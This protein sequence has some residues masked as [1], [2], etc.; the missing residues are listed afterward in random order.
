MTLSSRILPSQTSTIVEL[1]FKDR[2]PS[3]RLYHNAL[4]T[5][6]KE[7]CCLLVFYGPSGEGKTYLLREIYRVTTTNT[8]GPRVRIGTV[9]LKGRLVRESIYATMW[10]RA[11]LGKSNVRFPVYDFAFTLFWKSAYPDQP[12]PEMT[13]GTFRNFLKNGKEV[14][15]EDLPGR[16]VDVGV[17]LGLNFLK[18][19]P[20][21]GS[22]L[23]YFV[24]LGVDK[25]SELILKQSH[26]V[27]RLLFD[28]NGD[29]VS[30]FKLRNLLPRFLAYD[31][32]NYLRSHPEEKIVLLVDEYE[33]AL[34]L[35]GSGSRL[36]ESP[37]DEGIRE[38][39][40]HC[41]NIGILFV[42]FS[43][44][45]LPW[46]DY[47][48]GWDAV[49]KDAH[50]RV[51]SLPASDADKALLSAGVKEPEIRK[52]I[53]SAAL[54]DPSMSD[55][56]PV[57]PVML[58]LQL[59]HYIA[60]TQEQ[61]RT[62]VPSDFTV[63]SKSFVVR[64]NTLV[65]RFFRNYDDSLNR[66]LCRIAVAKWFDRPL[67]EFI[68]KNFNT[69]FP[70]DRFNDLARLSFIQR[71]EE[72]P[73]RFA[74]HNVIR[75]ALQSFLPADDSAATHTELANYLL[76]R[77]RAANKSIL[78]PE[79]V[80]IIASAMRHRAEVDRPTMWAEYTAFLAEMIG[81]F[82]AAESREQLARDASDNLRPKDIDDEGHS[83]IDAITSM[84]IGR[85]LL[86][87]GKQ[88]AAHEVLRKACEND[89]D[90]EIAWYLNQLYGDN[91]INLGQA[92]E[93]IRAAR[94]AVRVAKREFGRRHQHVLAGYLLSARALTAS[95]RPDKA[96][97]R[98]RLV[99]AAAERLPNDPERHAFRLHARMEAADC[100]MAMDRR[101][102]AAN[103]MKVALE[104]L[105]NWQGPADSQAVGAFFEAA[106]KCDQLALNEEAAD[107]YANAADILNK[108]FGENDIR[109]IIM[110]LRGIRARAL[111][112]NAEMAWEK[113]KNVADLANR[114]GGH[115]LAAELSQIV[116]KQLREEN[117]IAVAAALEREV[118]AD[119][120]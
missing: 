11:A 7:Q 21:V 110:E 91:L 80:E 116:C 65:R 42:F 107:L 32:E 118:V 6:P 92:S 117:S 59:G 114:A 45:K 115:Y 100:Y 30:D 46:S 66:T 14:V 113:C 74:I 44:E 36:R 28:E 17:E 64:R 47:D 112:D 102:D 83:Q 79:H 87:Q 82:G 96:M 22:A 109:V 78:Q 111:A 61:N 24:G 38:V 89:G 13:K 50:H 29:T 12:L 97:R 52:A 51:G 1:P 55:A 99:Q 9:D 90:G 104:Q 25:A 53:L 94:V 5:L 10:I 105:R 70:L 103:Q 26:S 88:E 72:Y 40:R 41:H 84:E 4:L 120:G 57:L 73:G 54:V 68:V 62:P 76:N 75:E 101:N 69:G 15:L 2:E 33:V 56:S 81:Q 18:D 95:G 43:R 119:Q 86:L 58:E 20:F 34:E 98:V 37:L 3:L 49:L 93:A 31:I 77:A 16:A 106:G 39:V 108:A 71:L 67:L 35:G 48:L 60:I 19:V 8:A 85:T 23:K 63:K 27:L